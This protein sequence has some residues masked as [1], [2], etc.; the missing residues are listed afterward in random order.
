MQS[1]NLGSVPTNW[2]SDDCLL[3]S[4]SF[5]F[6]LFPSVLLQRGPSISSILCLPAPESMQHSSMPRIVT[7]SHGHNFS[8]TYIV[9]TDRTTLHLCIL[10]LRLFTRR[11]TN[12]NIA[13]TP[14]FHTS[15]IC[16]S[17]ICSHNNFIWFLGFLNS[18]LT[19]AFHFTHPLTAVI[20]HALH[21]RAIHLETSLPGECRSGGKAGPGRHPVLHRK[22]ACALGHTRRGCG[23]R[24]RAGAGAAKAAFAWRVHGSGSDTWKETEKSFKSRQFWACH[25][26][27][28]RKPCVSWGY[29][30]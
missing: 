16:A 27:P 19:L 10:H 17:H 9:R 29:V 7:S 1:T 18:F 15:H 20:L 5:S 12:M 8:S 4:F 26:K 13:Y 22:A 14:R 24:T 30:A 6:S 23:C 28:W 2:F 11:Y 3:Y 25:E 21:S